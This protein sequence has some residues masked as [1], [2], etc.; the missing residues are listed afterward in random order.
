MRNAAVA[1]NVEP[2]ETRR[3]PFQKPKVAPAPRVRGDPGIRNM[4][5][6]T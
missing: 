4:Q 6:R 2:T 1:P 3:R 5:A